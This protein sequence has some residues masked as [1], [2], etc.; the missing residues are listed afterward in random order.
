MHHVAVLD[1]VSFSFD[2]HEALALGIRFAAYL[3]VSLKRDDF[4]ADKMLREV[5]MNFA[6]CFGCQGPF[7]GRPCADF[8]FAGCKKSD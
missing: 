5:G 2:L 3:H 1:F 6:G 8:F 7:A 4:G